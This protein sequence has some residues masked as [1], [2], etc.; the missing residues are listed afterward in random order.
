MKDKKDE[1]IEELKRALGFYADQFNWNSAGDDPIFL[2]E[3]IA[4]KTARLALQKVKQ[5][6]QGNEE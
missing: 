2:G 6:E 1:I 4:G 5:L 3:E